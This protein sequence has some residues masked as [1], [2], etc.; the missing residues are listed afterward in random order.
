MA[1]I[2][3]IALYSILHSQLL[4]LAEQLLASQLANIDLIGSPDHFLVAIRP[5]D[6][7]F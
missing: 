6:I 7:S 2:S 3:F 5:P 4:P 1:M